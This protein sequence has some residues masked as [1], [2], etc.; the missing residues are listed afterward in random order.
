MTSAL[1]FL[2]PT[3]KS[4]VTL[5]VDEYE[6]DIKK[7]SNNSQIHSSDIGIAF[8]DLI[9]RISDCV[10]LSTGTDSKRFGIRFMK[11]DSKEFR[12]VSED[13]T[14]NTNNGIILQTK[15]L[16]IIDFLIRL[17]DEGVIMFTQIDFGKPVDKPTYKSFAPENIGTIFM[18]IQSTKINEFIDEIY[19]SHI[20]PTTSL[21]GF[22]KRGYKT[23]EQGRFE[24]TQCASYIGILAAVLIAIFSPILMTH[25]STSTINEYQFNSLMNVIQGRDSAPKNDT[26]IDNNTNQ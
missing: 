17:K 8:I 1:D 11:S 21:I 23:V 16:Q 5:I 4:V 10:V 18:S 7:Y 24:D 6:N 14:F 20:V 22:K 13:T 2:D 25:C 15:V 12:S 9:K 3:T 19:F 26:I